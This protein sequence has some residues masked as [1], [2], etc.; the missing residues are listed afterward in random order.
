M[1]DMND[2]RQITAAAR[3]GKAAGGIAGAIGGAAIGTI[4]GPMGVLFGGIAGA[5]GGWWSGKTIAAITLARAQNRRWRP[6]DE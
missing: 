3:I 6:R 2:G 4:G 5:V 1:P